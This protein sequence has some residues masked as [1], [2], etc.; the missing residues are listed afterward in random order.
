MEKKLKLKKMRKNEKKKKKV[1]CLFLFASS[2]LIGSFFLASD[3]L[4][5]QK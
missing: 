4:I 3:W 5:G 2:F 1:V